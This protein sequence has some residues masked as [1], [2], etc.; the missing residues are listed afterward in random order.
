MDEHACL[1]LRDLPAA[2][3]PA[4][5]A[6]NQQTWP[7]PP[8]PAYGGHFVGD[9]AQQAAAA[10]DGVP[11][12]MATAAAIIEGGGAAV[13]SQVPYTAA[14]APSCCS[15]LIHILKHTVV[16]LHMTENTNAEYA[17]TRGAKPSVGRAGS[18]K[19]AGGAGAPRPG[20]R[21]MQTRRRLAR[22]PLVRKPD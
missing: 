12:S 8:G 11:Q 13:P 4:Q 19:S 20:L 1:W 17:P 9:Q 14:A 15:T 18:A 16:T 6:A 2:P 7:P 22:M 10:A 3:P 5:A 21:I